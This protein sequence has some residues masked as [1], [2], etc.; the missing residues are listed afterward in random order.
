[1]P[2]TFLYVQHYPTRHHINGL[3][4]PPVRGIEILLKKLRMQ[5]R[6]SEEPLCRCMG[7]AVLS[8]KH[9]RESHPRVSSGPN[10]SYG[11]SMISM[12]TVPDSKAWTARDSDT[13][14]RKRAGRGR[15]WTRIAPR[16]RA[17][18]Y[19]G[20]VSANPRVPGVWNRFKD[21]KFS[22]R[23]QGQDRGFR[24]ESENNK[25]PRQNLRAMEVVDSQKDNKNSPSKK[26]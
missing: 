4:Q 2:L 25:E 19:P 23:L 14:S 7:V 18:S 20:A 26:G 17:C 21:R 22:G 11:S 5:M 10:G 16:Y 15:I 9:A 6:V 24:R 13:L 12:M 1:M 8:A 3:R